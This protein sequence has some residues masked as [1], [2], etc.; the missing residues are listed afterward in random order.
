MPWTD[1]AATPAPKPIHS[2]TSPRPNFVL[3]S[4]KKTGVPSL[5]PSTPSRVLKQ[6]AVVGP[7]FLFRSDSAV[8]LTVLSTGSEPWHQVDRISC[9]LSRADRA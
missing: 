5:S 6:G 9:A 1:V 7:A 8:G 4:T 2:G 3:H